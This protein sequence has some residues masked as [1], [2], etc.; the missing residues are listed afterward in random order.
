MKEEQLK[1]L[2]IDVS[3]C[4]GYYSKNFGLEYGKE[5]FENVAARAETD[6]AAKRA[7]HERFG[8]LGLGDSDPKPIVQ[9]GYDD[10]LN[11]TLAF[12]GELHL[13]AD[14]TWTTP[15][16]HS[17]EDV[18]SLAVPEIEST[19]P[20]TH[21]LKKYEEAVSCVGAENIRPPKVHGILESALDV[22]GDAFLEDLLLEPQRAEKLLDVLTDTVIATKEFWDRKCYGEVR[23]GLSMGGCSTTMLSPST[24]E[25]FLVPRYS[26]ISKHFGDAF[27]CS[28]GESTKNLEAFAMI[29]ELRYA[30]VGWGTDLKKAAQ[31]LK[32]RHVKASVDVVRASKLSPDEFE[33]DVR[34]VLTELEPVDN[35]SLLLINAATDTPD[36]NVRRFIDIAREVADSYH[37]EPVVM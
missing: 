22:R 6:Q 21:F 28:C 29:E 7:L 27:L 16:L 26:R 14:V 35:V 18:D 24:V 36:E 30:R 2:E 23:S 34:K 11:V 8:D 5:Y 31:I 33:K 1:Y 13:G 17:A 10:T 20:H 37:I 32:E 4:R 3:F 25:K 12:G 9:L 15:V 19:W